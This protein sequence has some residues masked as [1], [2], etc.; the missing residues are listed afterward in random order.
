M[1]LINL[2]IQFDYLLLSN[3]EL[4]ILAY[5]WHVFELDSFKDKDSNTILLFFIFISFWVIESPWLRL[6]REAYDTYGL[7]TYLLIYIYLWPMIHT[8]SYIHTH[9]YTHV[10]IHMYINRFM[11][12][13][14][15]QSSSDIIIDGKYSSWI[16]LYILGNPVKK[17][18]LNILSYLFSFFLPQ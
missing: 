10:C 7:Y 17:N 3:Q 13:K 15:Y 4:V 16:N 1:N 18:Y 14:D 2:K 11:K 6:Y 9:V 12:Q 5:I 8:S